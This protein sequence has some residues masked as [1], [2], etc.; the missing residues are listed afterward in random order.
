[1]IQKKICMLGG[2][3]VGKTSL[4]GRFINNH[5]SDVYR[6][7]LGVKIDKKNVR[8]GLRELTLIVWDVQGDD[9]EQRL[10]PAYLRGMAGYLLVVDPTRPHT[11]KTAL[12]LRD[13]ATGLVG[14]K[15]FVLVMNKADLRDAWSTDS[16]LLD[17]LTATAVDVI[18][19][20][21]KT[22][23]GV[24]DGFEALAKSLVSPMAGQPS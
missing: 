21:A 19:T 22:G 3:A 18:E 6:T 24:D 7:T 12:E 5:F 14:P 11:I 1:V 23:M 2:F 8:I 4:A 13:Y 15:P 17:R 16:D 20:S 10:V 9:H